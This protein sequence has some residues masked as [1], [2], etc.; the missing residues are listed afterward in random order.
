[1]IVEERI[2]TLH[3]GK[4]PDY[5]R[6]YEN[7]GLAIQQPILGRLIGYFS[8]EFGALNQIVHL[9]GYDSLEERAK[10]RAVLLAD[11]GWKSYVAKVQPLIRTMENKLLIPTAF[12]PIR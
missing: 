12:S 4:V 11:A 2:Y 8:T 10:R 3:P 5:L 1:M 6:H 7:E 9:W